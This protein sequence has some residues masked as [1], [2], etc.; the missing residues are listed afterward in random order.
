MKYLLHCLFLVST[1]AALPF[2]DI[3]SLARNQ[4]VAATAADPIDT[5]T[6]TS[7]GFEFTTTTDNPEP[8]S[9]PGTRKEFCND[10]QIAKCKDLVGSEDFGCEATIEEKELTTRVTGRCYPGD[11]PVPNR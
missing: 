6:A 11:T 2:R 7:F 1:V 10:E 8:I 4:T 5:S 3:G 9:N